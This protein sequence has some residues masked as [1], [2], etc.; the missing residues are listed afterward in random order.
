MTILNSVKDDDRFEKD[1]YVMPNYPRADDSYVFMFVTDES[2]PHSTNVATQAVE[3]GMNMVTTTQMNAPT[4]S[5][6]A[7]LGGETI[8][9][10]DQIKKKI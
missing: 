10:M 9:D 6:T 2:E 8:D 4:I 3:H 7:V 1:A 5:V